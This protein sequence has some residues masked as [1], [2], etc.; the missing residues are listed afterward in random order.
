MAE[1]VGGQERVGAQGSPSLSPQLL[2]PV[3]V[4]GEWCFKNAVSRTWRP[5]WPQGDPWW[6]LLC[7]P[8]LLWSPVHSGPRAAGSRSRAEAWEEG[9]RGEGV[10]GE[11]A[12][13]GA[14]LTQGWVAWAG[15]L[16]VR[17]GP[18]WGASHVLGLP[19]QQTMNSEA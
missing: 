3:T 11:L 18:G 16:G 10:L 9:V 12:A 6:G 4:G 15:P 8:E 13:R 2:V 7:S 19:Q 17:V 5:S 14:R 1:G